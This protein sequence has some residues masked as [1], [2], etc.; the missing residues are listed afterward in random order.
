LSQPGAANSLGEVTSVEAQRAQ[1]CRRRR[2][3]FFMET[4]TRSPGNVR[5]QGRPVLCAPKQFADEKGTALEFKK[6]DDTPFTQH[7][8]C[9]QPGR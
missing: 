8:A 4:I 6:F 7:H 1:R 2:R 5:M 9:L 3:H